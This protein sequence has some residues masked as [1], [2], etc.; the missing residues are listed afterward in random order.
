MLVK[1]K[2]ELISSYTKT[3]KQ[4]SSF[5]GKGL[6]LSYVGDGKW[7]TQRFVPNAAISTTSSTYAVFTCN[8][9]F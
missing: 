6:S 1:E 4:H 7:P 8:V 5:S 2:K 3:C 9:V